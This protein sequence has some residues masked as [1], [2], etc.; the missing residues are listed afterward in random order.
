[1]PA[2]PPAEAPFDAFAKCGDRLLLIGGNAMIGYG[3]ERLTQDCDCAVVTE[4]ERLVAGVLQPLGYLFKERFSTFARYAHLGGR[5]PV[6]DVMLLNT[7]TFEKLRAQSREID[8]GGISLRAPKPL[9]LVA[10]KLH[11]LKQNPQRLGKDWE[12]IRYLLGHYE[13]SAEELAEVAERYASA[14]S[15]EMLR[16]AGF[17]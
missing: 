16:Q 11:A 9:H 12:D 13:W 14:E 5:R 6:V 2:Q 17:L 7:S 3:S 15:R 4:D 1:M 8:M 10:L